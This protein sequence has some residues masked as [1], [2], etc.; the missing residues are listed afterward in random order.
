MFALSD[1]RE[2]PVATACFLCDKHG[3]KFF[4]R[5]LFNLIPVHLLRQGKDCPLTGDL[6]LFPLPL[7]ST[8]K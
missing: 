8:L 5:S 4:Q 1:Y 7:R 6:T 2:Y 3:V